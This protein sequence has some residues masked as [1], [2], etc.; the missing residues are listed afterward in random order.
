MS[1][2]VSGVPWRSGKAQS[3]RMVAGELWFLSKATRAD[4]PSVA[5]VSVGSCVLAWLF[6]SI[7]LFLSSW[8]KE[9]S[10]RLRSRRIRIPPEKPETRAEP[11]RRE[12]KSQEG[13]EDQEEPREAPEKPEPRAEPWGRELEGKGRARKETRTRKSQGHPQRS[14]SPGQSQGE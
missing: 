5:L 8:Q 11:G 7:W 2:C 13:V 12:G 6:L 9:T 4:N 1:S 10:G 14:Q 3:F